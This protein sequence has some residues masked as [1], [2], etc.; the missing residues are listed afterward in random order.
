MIDRPG[1]CVQENLFSVLSDLSNEAS[2]TGNEK[3]DEGS[4]F[5]LIIIFLERTGAYRDR[6]MCES[7][8]NNGLKAAFQAKVRNRGSFLKFLVSHGVYTR[9]RQNTS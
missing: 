5:T 2:F 4:S 3:G 6:R 9:W 1:F 7:G 8:M